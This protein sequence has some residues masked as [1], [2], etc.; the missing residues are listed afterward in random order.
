MKKCPYCAEQIQNDARKCRYCGEMLDTEPAAVVVTAVAGG[1]GDAAPVFPAAF[2]VLTVAGVVALVGIALLQFGAGRPLAGAKV[3]AAAAAFGVLAPLAWMIA[4]GLRRLLLPAGAQGFTRRYGPQTAVL[5]VTAATLAWFGLAWRAPAV[6][7]EHAATAPIRARAAVVPA[8]APVTT[9][10]PAA[11]PASVA[12]PA[13]QALPD[14]PDAAVAGAAP[15]VAQERKPAA[16]SVS[17]KPQ[18][19]A[20]P[21]TAPAPVV[22]SPPA[23]EADARLRELLGGAPATTPTGAA[24]VTPQTRIERLL[25]DARLALAAGRLG[26]SGGDSAL[27]KYR[28]V[29]ALEPGNAQAREGIAA[30]ADAYVERFRQK[31]DAGEIDAAV[32]FL[33]R[34]EQ[35]D[36]DRP[37]V[38]TA[39]ETL[40]RYYFEHSR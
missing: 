32:Q 14:Q 9:T 15:T 16:K 28:A 2:Y 1:G 18:A 39:R 20:R 23:N 24:A 5:V 17:A 4:D 25:A 7:P 6:A 33:R 29:L 34:A 10:A 11:A 40:A 35:I 30:I 13:A 37:S 12:A 19:A 36:T 3:F 8:A 31:F 22:P 26:S 38:R 27:E 21:E